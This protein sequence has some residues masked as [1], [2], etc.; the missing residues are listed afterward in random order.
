MEM[1]NT[2]WA[3][4]WAVGCVTPSVKGN[5]CES[6]LRCGLCKPTKMLKMVKIALAGGCGMG[7]VFLA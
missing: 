6:G 7:L 3:F 1:V 2:I 5:N 4:I